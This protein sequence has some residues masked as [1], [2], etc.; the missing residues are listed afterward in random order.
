MLETTFIQQ[1][2][3]S[4]MI[5]VIPV[6]TLRLDDVLEFRSVLEEQR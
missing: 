6:E 2:H 4:H 3:N 1:E 5:S